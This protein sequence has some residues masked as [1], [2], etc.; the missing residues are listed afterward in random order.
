M[1]AK[2]LPDDVGPGSHFAL[3]Q[4]VGCGLGERASQQ[5][6]VI[7]GVLGNSID[8]PIVVIAPHWPQDNDRF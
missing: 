1:H 6:R 3:Q 4:V 5:E 2:A 7:Q 8:M